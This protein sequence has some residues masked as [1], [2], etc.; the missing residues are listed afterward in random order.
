M[1]QIIEYYNYEK[2][3]DSFICFLKDSVHWACPLY[4]QNC[5]VHRF[6]YGL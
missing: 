2:E 3:I 5:S 6:L 1:D 4:K